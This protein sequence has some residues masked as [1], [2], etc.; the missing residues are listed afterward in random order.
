MVDGL[1]L[2]EAAQQG[3]PGGTVCR[4]VAEEP[5][6]VRQPPS[7]EGCCPEG[8]ASATAAPQRRGTVEPKLLT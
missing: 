2:L 6:A 8:P 7:P 4:L 3:R 1:V 5:C